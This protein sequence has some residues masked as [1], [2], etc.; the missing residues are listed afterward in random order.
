M[1]SFLQCVGVPEIMSENS[2]EHMRNLKGVIDTIL[3]IYS[4]LRSSFSQGPI[5]ELM[6]GISVN[7]EA[8]QFHDL[9][10]VKLWFQV[11]LKP[12]LSRVSRQILSC[13]SNK[14][15]SCE[16]YQAVVEELSLHFSNMDPVRQRWIYMF[17]IEDWLMKNFGSF[18]AMAHFKDFT[19]LN[20]VF[21]GL[22]VLHLLTPE[23]K[24]ELILHPEVGGLDN[25]TIALV[26]ESLLK[27]LLENQHLNAS[28]LLYNMTTSA[29]VHYGTTLG[30]SHH[31]TTQ[32]NG[33]QNKNLTSMK[34]TTLTQALLNWTLA[35]LA[36]RFT[37]NITVGNEAKPTQTPSLGSFDITNIDDWFQHVVIPVLKRFLPHDQTEIPK[38][39]TAVFYHLL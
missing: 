3:D 28:R 9:D 26:F 1:S 38:N 20:I 35:E 8:V 17:F 11:K 37:Q 27:P 33:L 31:M 30:P 32:H 16:T 36:G 25:G 39:L 18:S 34:S 4:F 21:N 10:V 24:A 6:G 29:P 13:L 22:E 7:T 14:N 15:F 5:L 12:L 23:Q 2:M 19:T